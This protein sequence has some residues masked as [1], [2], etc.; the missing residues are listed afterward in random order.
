MSAYQDWPQKIKNKEFDF[1]L[2]QQ[3]SLNYM[4]IV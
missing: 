3:N 4:V 1:F 2:Q